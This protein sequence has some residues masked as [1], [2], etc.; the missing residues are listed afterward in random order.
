MREIR[1][2]L[3]SY[4]YRFGLLLDFVKRIAH[5]ARLVVQGDALWR[6]TGGQ[7]L[8]YRQ[9]RDAIVVHGE[10]LSPAN[11][12]RIK[13]VSRHC[14]GLDQDLTAFYHFAAG[15]QMLWRV[16]EPLVGLPIFCT[17]TVFE[18][19]ITLIIEQHITWKNALR[20]QRALMRIFDSG[21]AVGRATVYRFPSPK[22]VARAS[23]SELKAL[24]ITNRRISVISEIAKAAAD[25]SLHL[26]SLR[27]QE[28]A[29]AYDRLMTIKGVGHWTANN[30]LGR[31][32]GRYPAVSQNDVALQAAVL[33]YFYDGAGQKSPALVAQ[34]LERYGEYAGLAGHFLLLRWVLERYPQVSQES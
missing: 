26:E 14:L 34:T 6:F 33:R 21:I 30:A 11:E 27:H 3:P 25:G 10:S 4:A 15:E 23:H 2:P 24:K 12:D 18:A 13:R 28:A 5:P 31:A 9:E 7:L 8:A 29:A 16:V 20:Y 1:L 32:L 22:Q 19:L 17:E